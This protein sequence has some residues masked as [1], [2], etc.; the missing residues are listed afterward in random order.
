MMLDFITDIFLSKITI[1]FIDAIALYL[2][3]L[4]FRDDRKGK[5]NM[6]YVV[7][8]F[9]MLLWVNFAYIPRFI[10]QDD[11]V[12]SLYFL[13]IAWAATP[14]F[15]TFL[16]LITV[17]LIERE[18]EY[19]KLSIATVFTGIVSALVT[20]FTGKIVEGIKFIDGIFTIVYGRWMFL[21][22]G[23]VIFIIAATLYPIFRERVLK[24]KKIRYFLTGVIIFYIANAIFNIILPV[25]FGMARFYFIGDYSTIILLIYTA[26]GIIRF[27]LFNIKVVAAEVLT[28][29]IWLVLAINVFTAENIKDKVLA[30]TVLFLSVIFGVLLIRSVKNEIKQREKMERLTTQLKIANKRLR[31]LDTAKSEFISIASHQLRTPLTVIKGYVSMI[32][33]GDFGKLNPKMADPINK[34]SESSKRLLSL[35]EELLNISRIESGKLK[36]DF[37]PARLERVVKGVVGE[38]SDKAEA[39][40]LQLRYREKGEHFPELMLDEEKIRQAVVNLIDNAIKYTDKGTITV[41]LEREGDNIKFSVADTGPGIRQRDMLKLFQKFS[42]GTGATKNM[43]GSGL[44]LFI[45]NKMIKA[46]KGRIWAESRGEGYGSKFCFTLPV[47]PANN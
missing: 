21:F 11:T 34:I 35:V 25:F 43:E 1:L 2:A 33:A 29:L 12:R 47:K 38:L 6:I 16:Y 45:A 8:T 46:H 32:M 13:K 4:V 37:K 39:K 7:M 30:I 41:S 24:N 18:K 14:L 15:F 27:K 36:F 44:G 31:K 23:A 28:F 17:N 19:K 40:K 9:L 10:S 5:T 20:G 42:R 3:V 22:L 26:V